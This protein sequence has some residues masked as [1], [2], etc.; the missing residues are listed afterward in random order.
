M[1][2]PNAERGAGSLREGVGRC[3]QAPIVEPIGDFGGGLPMTESDISR[4][5][6]SAAGHWRPGACAGA[7]SPLRAPNGSDFGGDVAGNFHTDAYFYDD[8]R[9]PGHVLLLEPLS[10]R[11]SAAR[12][13]PITGAGGLQG[14]SYDDLISYLF[15][16]RRYQVDSGRLELGVSG[17]RMRI[18]ASARLAVAVVGSSASFWPCGAAVRAIIVNREIDRRIR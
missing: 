15:I 7:V 18:G 8:G 2:W 14:D 6:E 12:Q 13:H 16:L 1:N 10:G 9:C 3:R 4:L 5:R 17:G 11:T